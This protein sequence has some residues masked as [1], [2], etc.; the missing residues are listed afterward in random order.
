MKYIILIIATCA[1]LTAIAQKKDSVLFKHAAKI[2]LT[3]NKNV[4]DNFKS[5]GMALIDAGYMIGSKDEQFGQI[6]SGQI[7]LDWGQQ[8]IYV[9][10]KDNEVIIT[11]KYRS[12]N[13]IKIISSANNESEY[14]PISYSKN[15]DTN[16]NC[17]SN[18]V[19]VAKAIGYS[20]KIYSE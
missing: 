14:E 13:K 18:M 17:F 3:N 11:S 1:C 6:T 2:I 8:I 15:N 16:I 7:K 9:I 10:V 19:K 20:K 4:S 12:Y 5:A